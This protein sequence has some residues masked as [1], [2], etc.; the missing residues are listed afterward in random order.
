MVFVC[1][2]IFGFK[3][4]TKISNVKC[5]FVAVFKTFI[6]INKSIIGAIITYI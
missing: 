1:C 5:D 2:P 6:T 3:N 4:S